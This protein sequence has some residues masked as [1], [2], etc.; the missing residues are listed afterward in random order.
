[1]RILL[2]RVKH[3]S[4]LEKTISELFEDQVETTPNQ[5]AVAF[6]DNQ[7]TYNEL[8]HKVNQLAHHIRETY[9]AITHQSLTPD[10]LIPICLER[11]IEMIVG[12]FAIL[13]AGG[14][15][16]PIDPT[17][18]SAR[19]RY[20]IDDT[21]AI[22][23][24]T[25]THLINRLPSL[26]SWI[27][28]NEL[29]FMPAAHNVN[30]VLIS[31]SNHLAYVIYTSG[32]TGLP[33]GVCV[34]Q[35]S[36]I[37]LSFAQSEQFEIST[38][39]R[40][41]QFA[42]ISFDAAVS[43]IFTALLSGARLDLLDSTTRMDVYALPEFMRK[44]EISVATLP[45]ALLNN[46]EYQDLPALKTLI[47]AGE[48]C[49]A[50]VME[51]WS[52]GRRLFN[53]YGPTEATVCATMNEYQLND[54]NT[55]IG[56]PLSNVQ[57]YILDR[58]LQ[59]V[60]LGAIGEIYIGGAG[61]SRG[62]LNNAELTKTCF[63]PNPF[64]KE[65]SAYLYKTGDLAICLNNGHF[66]YR[67]R[68]DFQC[69]INGY[70]V[71]LSEV[72]A[73]LNQHNG[74]KAAVVQL[75]ETEH[76]RM[77]VGYYTPENSDKERISWWPSIAEYYVYDNLL[78]SMM[79]NHLTR[80]ECYRLAIRDV[81]RDKIVLDVG[82]G[83]D[84]ILSRLCIEEGA[85]KVYAIEYL[86]ETYKKAKSTIQRYQLEDKIH[87]ILGD[88]RK[89]TLPEQ[90]DVCVSEI[91]GAIGGSEGA[92]VILNDVRKRHLKKGAIFIPQRCITNIAAITLP[93]SIVQ[94]PCFGRVQHDYTQ[95]IFEQV[96]FEFDLRL[97]LKGVEYQDLASSIDVFEDLSWTTDALV[98]TNHCHQIKLTFSQK[99]KI[100]GFLL[101]LSLMTNEAN[102]LDILTDQ[103]SWLPIYLPVFPQGVIVNLG[104]T[105]DAS[106]ERHL[107]E[108]GLNFDYTIRGNL[109]C[110]EGSVEFSYTSTHKDPILKHNEFYENFFNMYE[111]FDAYCLENIKQFLMQKLPNYMIPSTFIQLETLPLTSNGKVDRKALPHFSGVQEGSQTELST[112]LEN[113]IAE[114]WR[115]VLS[116]KDKVLYRES[117]FFALG[118]Q[119]LTATQVMAQIQRD[120]KVECQ[121]N[122]LFEHS[123]LQD[124]AHY[125]ETQKQVRLS[126]I[127]HVSRK[128]EIPLSYG[129]QRLWFLDQ[130]AEGKD[131]SYM[132]SAVFE[133]QGQLNKSVLEKSI[134]LL[135]T[136]HE[137][138]R[139]RVDEKNGIG[140][141]TFHS[142][143]RFK[144]NI[145]QVTPAKQDRALMALWET[146]FDLSNSPLVEWHLFR[147]SA[148][149]HLLAL[150]LHHI[151]TDGWSFM[152]LM[153]ELQES[154]AALLQDKKP[155]LAPLPF[156]Y[157]DFA[158][159]QRQ[160]LQKG[161]LAQQESYWQ[162]QLMNVSPILDLPLDFSRPP[163]L[164]SES[165]S[166]SLTL[167]PNLRVHL[168]QTAKQAG[169][170]LFMVL[171][172]G[173]SIV[174]H[175]YSRQSDFLIGSAI[176][177]RNLTDLESIQGFFVN[178]LPLRQKI[179]ENETLASL[180]Q[181]TKETCLGAYAH[182][183]LPFEY[184]V[185][186]LNVPRDASRN[187]LVQVMVSHLKM[188][189][190]NFHL[191][192]PYL[193]VKP[194]LMPT[195]STQS[196]LTF[197]FM[198]GN[199]EL[200]LTTAFNTTLFTEETIKR[201]NAHLLLLYTQFDELN[202]PI[203]QLEILSS[204]EKQMLLY[205]WNQTTRAYPKNKTI[206]QL[207]E[208]QVEKTPNAIAVVFESKQLTYQDLNHRANQVARAIQDRYETITHQSLASDTLI[209]IC[210]E[211]SP[212]MIIGLLAILKS[213]AAYVPID[214]EYPDKRIDYILEDTRVVLVLTHNQFVKRLDGLLHEPTVSPWVVLDD[215]DALDT[216]DRRNLKPINNPRDLAYVIYT[217]GSTG[218]PKGVMIEH[219]SVIN[220]V[221]NNPYAEL[222]PSTVTAAISNYAFDG[223][224]FDIFGTL[225]NGGK[226]VLLVKDEFLSVDRL[227]CVIQNNKINTLFMTTA[228]F[229]IFSQIPE[230]QELQLKQLLFGGERVDSEKV[231]G[232]L[233]RNKNTQLTHV[234]GPTETVVF[235]SYFHVNKN[236][237]SI[238]IGKAVNGKQLYVLDPKQN[239]VPI[240]VVGE[241]YIGGIGLARG[242]LNNP[243]LTQEKFIV[244]PFKN[245]LNER[246]YKTGDLVRLLSD[247]NIEYIGRNDFQVKI[248]GFRVELGEIESAL[249]KISRVSQN[250]V[251][252][253]Q[254]DKGDETTNL[255]V[256]YY[257]AEE[258]IDEA[259]LV[260]ALSQ[261][262]PSHMI[263]STFV[264]MKAFPLTSNGKIDRRALPAPTF[265]HSPEQTVLPTSTIEQKLANIW[266]TLLGLDTIGIHDDFFRIGGDSILSIQLV[267]KLRYE[268]LDCQVKDIFDHRTIA[269]LAKLFEHPVAPSIVKA[270][271]K[272]LSGSF[273]L[274]PIQQWFFE[275]VHSGLF[276]RASHWNQ[277]FM[278]RV[279]ILDLHQLQEWIGKLVV[280]HDM[281]R[282]T[283]P[284][285]SLGK[286]H[287]NSQI[288]VPILKTLDVSTCNKAMITK[289]LSQ[290]QSHFNL[291]EGPLWQVGY[292]YG[293]PDNSARLYFAF[294][295]L[296][297]DVVSW[298]ILIEDLNSLYQGNRLPK[299][300]SSYR[301]WVTTIRKYA[302][303]HMD[304]REY[305]LKIVSEFESISYDSM[306]RVPGHSFEE[307]IIKL[308]KKL[309][310]KLLHQSNQAYFT[311]INDLL[312]AALAYAL[313]DW[314]GATK[315]FITL[316]GHGR[317]S[318]DKTIDV[319]RT[320]GWFT[321]M[322]PVKLEIQADIRQT[323][324]GIKE[325]LRQIPNRGIG[326]SALI[327][328]PLPAV[329][330][331][332]LGQFDSQ[333]G[334]WQVLDEAT[335]IKI[336]PLNSDD[337]IIDMVGLVIAG[338]FILICN[339]Q[340][341]RDSTQKMCERFEFHLKQILQHC[342]DRLSQN[343]IEFT[344]SDF[345]TVAS[346]SDLINLPLRV[347]KKN[348]YQPF[349]MTEMQKAYLLGRM[350]NFEIGSIANHLYQEFYFKTL[351]ID[352]LESALNQLI[353]NIPELRTV[354]DQNTLTQRYLPYKKE[355]YYKI[356][357]DEY[358]HDLNKTTMQNIRKVKSHHVYDAE[359]Y[360]LFDFSVSRFL[361]GIVLHIN[362]DL[363]LLD[364]E[365]RKKFFDVL[366]DIYQHQRSSSL[367]TMR[368]RDY[369]EYLSLLRQSC[370]Y[371]KDQNYWLQLIP[372]L[373][374]RPNLPLL[375]KPMDVKNPVFKL[376]AKTI[377]ADIWQKFKRKVESH[378]VS[379]SAALLALYGLV[380]SRWSDNRSFLMTMT[381]FNRY[382]IHAEVNDIWGDFT[383]SNLF[384]FERRSRQNFITFIRFIHDRMWQNIDHGLYTGL[385]VQRDLAKYHQLDAH[386]AVS[387]II[388]TGRVRGE[389]TKGDYKQYV[390]DPSEIVS[391][392][393][394][395]GQTSQA[396]IDLQA[397]E[398]DDHFY[399]GWIYVK[400]LFDASF[401]EDL[402]S[403][404]CGLITF[405]ADNDWE[406]AIPDCVNEKYL[407]YRDANSFHQT[408]PCE[409][410]TTAVERM[411]RAFPQHTAII[412]VQ[413]H[414]C[415]EKIQQ[416][417]NGIALYLFQLRAP[418]N[419]LVGILSQKGYQQVVSALGIMRSGLA[420]LPLHTEWPL[421]RIDEVLQEGNV[422]TIL[423]SNLQ[424]KEIKNSQLAQKYNFVVIEEVNAIS[425][426]S[427]VPYP[428]LTDS[429][430]VIFTSGSTGK[431]KG[432]EIS[433]YAAMNTLI[434]VNTRF[435]VQQD[436][437]IFALSELSFDLS[438]Y[439][440]FGLL[441]AGA[442]IVFPEPNMDK[443]PAYWY[444]LIQKHNI[445]IWNTVP[446]LLQLL[447][448]Y[449]ERNNKSLDTLKLVMMSGDWIPLKLPSQIKSIHSNITVMSL[450][451]ATEG[452]IWSIWY[453]VKAVN[454]EWKAIPYGYA[455]P[456]QKM[457]VLNEFLE[458]CPVGVTG[459]IYIGGDGVATGYWNNPEK[460]QARFLDT[461]LGRL[462][463]TGDLGKWHKTGYIEFQGRIDHQIKLNGYRIELDEVSAKLAQLSGIE[464]AISTIEDN[465]IVSY[466]V[467]Q[468]FEVEPK[469][470][471]FSEF[472]LRQK[473][474][475]NNLKLSYTLDLAL[476]EQRYRLRKSYRKFK[477]NESNVVSQPKITSLIKNIQKNSLFSN[478]KNNKVD[479]SA[480]KSILS[481]I[482]ALQLTDRVLPK[483][484]YPSAGSSYAIRTYLNVPYD[485]E[486]LKA[487]QYYYHP[488]QHS[489]HHVSK[490]VMNSDYFALSFSLYLPA[491]E[492]IYGQYS[493]RFAYIEIGH[494]LALIT[495]TSQKLD[496][497]SQYVLQQTQ[498][499]NNRSLGFLLLGTE[500]NKDILFDVQKLHCLYPHGEC[501]KNKKREYN[502]SKQTIFMRASDLGNILDSASVL[503]TIDD[504][505][506]PSHFVSS[507]YFIQLLTEAGYEENIGSCVLGFKPYEEV[508]YSIVLGPITEQ[509]KAAAEILNP[510]LEIEQYIAHALSYFLPEYMLPTR[511]V[512]LKTLPLTANGKVDYAA[513]KQYV[514]SEDKFQNYIKASDPTEQT[515]VDIWCDIL[516]VDKIGMRDHFFR[517]GGHSLSAT[518]V[519]A[520][521]HEELGADI[522][523]RDLFS[524]PVAQEFCD[525]VKKSQ[526][527]NMQSFKMSYVQREQRLPLS[528]SEQRLWF[529]SYYQENKSTYNMFYCYSLC[530]HLNLSA[531]QQAFNFL[532]ARHENLRAVF[533]HQDGSPYKTI[534]SLEKGLLHLEPQSI[535]AEKLSD[536][537]K[538]DAA[539]NFNLESGRLYFVKL[540]QLDPQK[541]MLCINMHHIIND[542]WGMGIFIK[543]LSQ[544]YREF[545]QS[546]NQ[547]ALPLLKFNY[548]DYA[549]SQ[550]QWF[551]Q[552][553]F[554]QQLNFWKENLAD[555]APLNLPTD[556]ERPL[557]ESMNGD[558]YQFAIDP[559]M[560]ARINAFIHEENVTLFMFLHTI[561]SIILAHY[562]GQEDIVIGTLIANRHRSSSVEHIIGFFV[563]SLCLRLKFEKNQ[564]FKDCLQLSKVTCLRAYENQDIP[565]ESLVEKLGVERDLS[566]H[567]IYQVLLN[568][569]NEG[570]DSRL[571]LEGLTVEAV[572]NDSDT[573]KRDLTFSCF[574]DASEGL[575]IAIEYSKDLFNQMTIQ[576]LS[577]HINVLIKNAIQTPEQPFHTLSF[578]TDTDYNC[579]INQ[580][581]GLAP[582]LNKNHN[583]TINQLLDASFTLNAERTA[584]IDADQ[585]ISYRQ[586]EKRSNQIAHYLQAFFKR[587][588]GQ[589]LDPNS[590][591]A[592]CLGRDI[593]II[594][595]ILGILKAGAAYMPMDPDYKEEHLKHMLI[596]A[597]SL[598]LITDSS[599]DEQHSWF[600]DLSHMSVM[601]IDRE[602]A[603]IN[604]CSEDRPE[605][606]CGPE[607][608]AYVIYTSGSSGK[609]K[610]VMIEHKAFS[611]Y[612]YS[613]NQRLMLDRETCY[614]HTASFSFSS[615]CRQ[616]FL[617][618]C[619][620]SKIVIAKESDKRDALLLFKLI[621]NQCV[622]HIDFV[623][624]YWKACNRV[625][626]DLSREEREEYLDNQLKVVLTASEKIEKSILDEWYQQLGCTTQW[627]NMY[628]QTETA[629]ICIVAD[630]HFSLDDIDS[631]I[632]G[633]P[634]MNSRAL[635]L[636]K[637]NE[638][639]PPGFVGELCVLTGSVMRGYLHD[640]S[641]THEKLILC[642]LTSGDN[643]SIHFDKLYKTGDLVKWSGT[644]CLNYIGRTDFQIKLRGVK[645][646]PNEISD[647]LKQYPGISQTVV[648][649]QKISDESYLI[650]YYV[651]KKNAITITPE[652]LREYL[653]KYL[654]HFMVP[655]F[656]VS[657]D[658]MPRTSNGKID[659]RSL[660]KVTA[661]D[662][663][664]QGKFVLPQTQMEKLVAKVM[665][666]VLALNELGANDDFF[667]MGGN[668]L[669]AMQVIFRIER[670]L[671]KKCYVKHLF[672]YPT[673][674]GFAKYLDQHTGIL[675]KTDNS[676]II[677]QCKREKDKLF[678]LSPNQEMLWF[679]D[680]LEGP[681]SSY[682]IPIIYSLR[683]KLNLG[684]LEESINQL[685]MRHESLR[686]SFIMDHQGAGYQKINHEMTRV[687]LSAEP[688]SSEK[689]SEAI[690]KE[691]D[692]V[693]DLREGRPFRVRLFELNT[694]E[695]ILLFVCHHI[696]SDGWSNEILLRD[697][698]LI[699]QSI[700]DDMQIN[701]P[702]LPIQYVDYATWINK[703][704]RKEGYQQS[705]NY[706][707]DYLKNYTEL[708]LP[709]DKHRPIQFT[710]K[711]NILKFTLNSS[712]T[713]ALKS[714]AHQQ[715]VTLFIVL[716]SA[717][718]FLLSRYS[719]QE[720]I[721]L[722]IPL[723]GR[724]NMDLENAVGFF[725]NVLVLRHAISREQT[726]EQLI[727][728]V[729]TNFLNA[730]EHQQ[731][732]FEK[733]V[734]TL[735]VS[736]DPGK[737]PLF[738]VMFS[739]GQTHLDSMNRF[740]R[741]LEVTPYI[742]FDYHT[743][744]LDL[745]LHVQETADTI[746]GQFE[747]CTDLFNHST[748]ENISRHFQLFLQEAV[749]E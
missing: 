524:H 512:K 528:F 601:K 97:C 625:L 141:Q 672:E 138:L 519:V 390:I 310:N 209:G 187:P 551:E 295:H 653:K 515:I 594:Y 384:G 397:I 52:K 540:Y 568:V 62:Y 358:S 336:D 186:K 284:Q 627:I 604:Q 363:I 424:W 488:V 700:I 150:K 86:E 331:N 182:Q 314:N 425:D 628:G 559:T 710:Y 69:K 526:K 207:F 172:T 428:Q 49:D 193:Q 280:Q 205:D 275:R 108:N 714:L 318:I 634:L 432:V 216:Y 511:Y 6:G 175:R 125:L 117:D 235:S 323:I 481:S 703:E 130:Y 675:D 581:G 35:S 45:P 227:I 494:M 635:V 254:N 651:T 206:H 453:E 742:D 646:N 545:C 514:Q 307:K 389:Q 637:W 671:N 240:G 219:E 430:Y 495:K 726:F 14:A 603:E 704:M 328:H 740:G 382:P 593:N 244:N 570:A 465:Q 270:E 596:D 309:T 398:V 442:A 443:D 502:L 730:S 505:E 445:S 156:Q 496:I 446:Q 279:P 609:P 162:M 517:L 268:H 530:G 544:C 624:S 181:K 16:V 269:R 516:E 349:P 51:R 487:G 327:N 300:T 387:P 484:L 563:N 689:V 522:K 466:L 158:V 119:S 274:L 476:D 461:Q 232:F 304:E 282:V 448:E 411:A 691:I 490:S 177:G 214:P 615:S 498:Q 151:I 644:G 597:K 600:H 706:W 605:N 228:L 190:K 543:E 233:N 677:P 371:Q 669:N 163:K 276:K 508:I 584:I 194:L 660:P 27:S 422:Q 188:S 114:I 538:K 167:P 748:I 667:K 1:M 532:V 712:L 333:D 725:V 241:L 741:D 37:N 447:I 483:Y 643:E 229:N 685:V 676:I 237:D 438:V 299:K 566:R 626:L 415:Y 688:I 174:L 405:L 184:L 431:P 56:T 709:L 724:L 659:R 201:L 722:G 745:T 518:R 531:L 298:R 42:S 355:L 632:I 166:L 612:L 396:W 674:Y 611:N 423:I 359:S 457:Y 252:L 40:V 80:N 393:Y 471:D 322:Y 116:L 412:D 221:I 57:V 686:T 301:Q 664:H 553:L 618:L 565:F 380:L 72:E 598:L 480:I 629:G 68:N 211:R 264:Y 715:G 265:E 749:N 28:L 506:D 641:K 365:S 234:Y 61:V 673:V 572:I 378:G 305:W 95:K 313:S 292:L 65:S 81:V 261:E 297:I 296:I 683:G 434:A 738:Q 556:F 250:I 148:Q 129:Q 534:L 535:I 76:D 744:K 407:V 25:Q 541:Y 473:G 23:G 546:N 258:V 586:L 98:P 149:K 379:S 2:N 587:T 326:Y 475:R 70:R 337:S 707:K 316:E 692:G 687:I 735:N 338:E 118:G 459:E 4:Q 648:V 351:A 26:N 642:T 185:D 579:L 547:P 485:S 666:E 573:A 353:E 311:E 376:H 329:R 154:Y 679:M 124:L 654:P 620:G 464:E 616:L 392:R 259:F 222:R 79:T 417:S 388:F 102:T 444:T 236:T 468:E 43:E 433:H 36:L 281:L 636:G 520:R 289:V 180:L 368:F 89:I 231:I 251:L 293:Y 414:H 319:T 306:N 668:S 32:T 173:L 583:Q 574:E 312:L 727:D 245:D 266:Q 610:G 408:P 539:H 705:L 54:L 486:E 569:H 640:D 439:D 29:P 571:E 647:K 111:R 246:L 127:H 409:T 631:A 697:F 99:S 339:T 375:Q 527:Q 335:G 224:V 716:L 542:A 238:P 263:P 462:Y 399:S 482:S 729:K 109:I 521:V 460:T 366:G 497:R 354:F 120:I 591:V 504:S 212:D 248:R 440:M 747:Y 144:L 662:I 325:N 680:Q 210:I 472:K 82:T 374:L 416:L 536:I 639:M 334:M 239:L 429:A 718:K 450:G 12:I 623:P 191:E 183:D 105:I 720:D 204:Q 420:Y 435:H 168:E 562:A 121:L 15:Y 567:P 192:L 645:I 400:Q 226:L 630:T 64:M 695:Y 223:S 454:P 267:S 13:K 361:D 404:Y 142:L 123:K 367:P 87:L 352:N 549:W 137:G 161:V 91:V 291:E 469:S 492:P 196:D 103:Q 179:A 682:N 663:G 133:L 421:G 288:Q 690:S 694:E 257:V 474:L 153:V 169:V 152:R 272:R 71:E 346:E 552:G 106:V 731:V 418:K 523:V 736:R 588:Q 650:V 529:L 88:S 455:M 638:L 503:L 96:G 621:K 303:D 73:V 395:M 557:I 693:F 39:S 743:A 302:K 176:A 657:L 9:Q 255:L 633:R 578:L 347:D 100:H 256:A 113:K 31:K 78:Y 585:H 463:K 413:G 595:V 5:V 110:S 24:L 550:T 320:V 622:T 134:E 608:L 728:S 321:T 277:S 171:L 63:I 170:T 230:I 362:I 90:C 135:M 737:N 373:P 613:L 66:E 394:W 357:I 220:L 402:N 3:E 491:I 345:A 136:R 67:G 33:K 723:S 290:W 419:Q 386:Q 564:S 139:M 104:D 436:D 372:V 456:N 143:E 427:G 561:I 50:T 94:K 385:E 55:D 101:W 60:A 451:G 324:R 92:A 285:D 85:K 656:Y 708:R 441:M 294:H 159:W 17:Y 698:S 247:G 164:S 140:Y 369:Q 202:K 75:Q 7:L 11:S 501:F 721:I 46:I 195:Q 273:P 215:I 589:S 478:A 198:E 348:L 533:Q 126:T 146:P 711:G 48:V 733:I 458:H 344:P 84:V 356:K 155:T 678:P 20:I 681:N 619:N 243:D 93:E 18:P 218:D 157:A 684:V 617:P 271:Q 383:S 77:L 479:F 437:R 391:Q 614:L 203:H 197:Y 493:E 560:T 47:I 199:D 262:L 696:V 406:H 452:S 107:C 242:Y 58:D 717:F 599:I 701:L 652:S 555:I 22:L 655:S 499:G 225:L 410:M 702:R 208:D 377:P 577:E 160:W 649:D 602:Y 449:A 401:I 128:E 38:E 426:I 554:E 200:S 575:Q 189:H 315:H 607:S 178:T 330:F 381:L 470:A 507:G 558:V 403:A 670:Q 10:T 364:V 59:P 217:S 509:A 500:E 719:Q 145:H 19:I 41:L 576:R 340:F 489:L 131:R 122:A 343:I 580:W 53:A 713:V 213:G 746:E 510:A 132:M 548:V 467:S 165:D 74:V 8:N 253:Y 513:L 734:K 360:P 341:G 732:P 350:A 249:N 278:V 590:V 661:D 260:G 606:E 34:E 44:R 287:Y 317:E 342:D 525:C 308:D 30:P 370:W 699:Y 21:N 115:H 582:E 739:M 286:Q 665:M 477:H 658:R 112:A 83:P 537:L 147:V 592:V 332:Y 283:Y